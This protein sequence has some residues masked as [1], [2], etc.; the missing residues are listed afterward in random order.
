MREVSVCSCPARIITPIEV[1]QVP[2]CGQLAID[3]DVSDN[4]K[5]VASFPSILLAQGLGDKVSSCSRLPLSY[6]LLKHPE[7]TLTS[8]F[9][10]LPTG[11]FSPG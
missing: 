4:W 7:Q 2:S 6:T 9:V 8:P 10:I 11:V 3:E 5:P 1:P